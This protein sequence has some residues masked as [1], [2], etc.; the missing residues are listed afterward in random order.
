MAARRSHRRS[1]VSKK[2]SHA[3]KRSHRRSK[4]SGGRR[5]RRRPRKHAN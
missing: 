1:K 3:S 5:S 4:K 2:K